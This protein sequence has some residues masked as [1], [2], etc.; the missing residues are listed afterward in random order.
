M[1]LNQTSA[2]PPSQSIMEPGVPHKQ[3]NELALHEYCR[4]VTRPTWRKSVHYQALE[5]VKRHRAMVH[6]APGRGQYG[7]V[8]QSPDFE[9]RSYLHP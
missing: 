4:P 2:N 5:W 7:S 1:M 8:L 6:N 3:V 9:S